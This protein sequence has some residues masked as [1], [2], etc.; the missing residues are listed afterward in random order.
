V[1]K[2]HYRFGFDRKQFSLELLCCLQGKRRAFFLSGLDVSDW[3]VHA[4]LAER[5]G[6]EYR[7]VEKRIRSSEA[8]AQLAADYD[9]SRKHDVMVSPILLMN[10]GRQRLHGNVGYRLIEANVK[11]LLRNPSREEA[12]WC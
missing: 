10:D 2:F 9:L 12:S 4:E 6:I 8:V 7:A 1:G 3:A 11:E 5:L